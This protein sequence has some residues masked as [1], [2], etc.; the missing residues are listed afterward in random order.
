MLFL[1]GLA[2]SSV[3]M[4]VAVM[5]GRVVRKRVRMEMRSFMV[6]VDLLWCVVCIGF[7]SVS[8]EEKW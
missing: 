8:G 2:I 5:E 3:M 1:Q 7:E 4:G 6:G